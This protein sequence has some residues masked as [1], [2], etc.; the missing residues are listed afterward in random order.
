MLSAQSGSAGFEGDKAMVQI[1]IV[2]RDGEHGADQTLCVFQAESTGDE[3]K[4]HLVFR[5]TVPVF[6]EPEI[7]RSPKA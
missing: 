5:L 2:V 4:M 3:N 6:K 1:L 7:Y